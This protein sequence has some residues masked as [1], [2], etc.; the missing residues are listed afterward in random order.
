VP[1][2]PKPKPVPQK[3]DYSKQIATLNDMGFTDMALINNI[4]D[5]TGGNLDDALEQ[6]FASQG[7]L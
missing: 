2:P 3:P 7:L 4:L 1:P 5:Y 6:L